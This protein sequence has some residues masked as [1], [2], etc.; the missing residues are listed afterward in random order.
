MHLH[1]LHSF[2]STAVAHIQPNFG[3]LLSILSL[4]TKDFIIVAQ[5]VI[6]QLNFQEVTTSSTLTSTECVPAEP[7]PLLD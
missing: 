6:F 1:C 3:R 5:I 2:N 7:K 4:L